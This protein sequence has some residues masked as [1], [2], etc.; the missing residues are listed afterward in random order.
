MNGDLPEGWKT[1]ELHNCVDVLDSIR[2][3]VNSDER[4]SRRGEIPYYGATGQVGWIDDFL[5]DEEILLIGEDGAP[6]FDK[7]KPIAYIVSGKSWVNN[8]AHVLRARATTSTNQYLKHFL[9]WF[10]FHDYVNGTTR[11]KLTQGSMN[12]IPVRLAPIPEQ[13]RIVAQVEALLASVR[14][15]QERLDKIPTM[16]KRFRQAVLGAACNGNLTADWRAKNRPKESASILL[17]RIQESL[18]RSAR[19]QTVHPD[20]EAESTDEIPKTW[21]RCSLSQLFSIQTGATP[22][23]TNPKYHL[24]GT[25][26][27][28]KTGEVQN[29]EIWKAEE[30]IT[31]QAVQETNAKVFP[32]GTLLIAMYGEGKTRGQV[33]RLQIEAA[34][35]QASAALVNPKL[36]DETNRYVFYFALSQYLRLRAEAVG[37]NQPNLSLRIIKQWE[38]SFPPF[39]EQKEIV[40]RIESLLALADRLEA[41]YTKAKAQVDRRLRANWHMEN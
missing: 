33:G 38:L 35:N 13:R 4:A 21:I 26:P 17:G 27:W 18:P 1:T 8:H 32:I 20:G 5:F 41:R 14:S 6:F 34:T 30:Y 11:L 39:D 12:G 23:K 19:G 15:S 36:P 24:N 29:C 9:D 7:S 16:L 37:G 2:V 10:E 40:R 25:I 31:Q 22:L 28:V 3:P